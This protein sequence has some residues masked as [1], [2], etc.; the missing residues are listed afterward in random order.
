[1]G[2][3]YQ[4]WSFSQSAAAGLQWL[5]EGRGDHSRHVA[6]GPPGDFLSTWIKWI[7]SST[8]RNSFRFVT[9]DVVVKAALKEGFDGADGTHV[10]LMFPSLDK[11]NEPGGIEVD[12]V[13]I[14]RWW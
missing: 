6:G 7:K 14:L 13:L 9:S 2:K 4:H 10:V 5:S 8:G 1:M 11:G 3:V 12:F